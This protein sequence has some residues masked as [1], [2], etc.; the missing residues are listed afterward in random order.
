[1]FGKI[2]LEEH[3]VQHGSCGKMNDQVMYLF[4]DI[5]HS[6]NKNLHIHMYFTFLSCI[7][8]QLRTWAK[9]VV[10]ICTR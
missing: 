7:V 3:A 9:V 1:M 2:C 4:L 6:G 10:F 5:Y 8:N